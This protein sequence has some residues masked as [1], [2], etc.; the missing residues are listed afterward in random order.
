MTEPNEES[1]QSDVVNDDFQDYQE[2]DGD[3]AMEYFINNI[4]NSLVRNNTS[5]Y[6]GNDNYFN[7]NPFME[8]AYNNYTS[9]QD[10]EDNIDE[11]QDDIQYQNSYQEQEQYPEEHYFS[12]FANTFNNF[13]GM[14]TD[15]IDDILQQSFEQQPQTIE[16]TDYNLIISSQEFKTLSDEIKNDN[17]ECSI[18][19]CEYENTDSIS[20]TNCNHIFHT[21][22]I[23]EW[24]KYK[25]ECPLCKTNLV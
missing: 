8:Y 7:I 10:D 22:C 12:I 19:V 3:I 21:D 4:F 20:I 6:N 5:I 17:K 24:G 18:C 2:P 15:P 11:E 16:K 25:Q 14:Y 9:R 1:K 23:K 13:M